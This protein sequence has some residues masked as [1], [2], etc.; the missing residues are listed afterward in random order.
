MKYIKI[1]KWKLKIKD[2]Q[3]M[4]NSINGQ[5]EN[6]KFYNARQIINSI[7]KPMNSLYT[8]TYDNGKYGMDSMNI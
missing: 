7:Y 6:K 3:L 1:H 4:I 2:C 5:S 8:Y